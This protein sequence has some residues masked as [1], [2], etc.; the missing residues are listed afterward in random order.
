MHFVYFGTPRFSS[1][2]LQKIIA[3]KFIP[4]LVI[5]QPPRPRGRG[6]AVTPSPVGTLAKEYGIASIAPRGLDADTR[7]QLRRLHPDFFIVAAYGEIFKKEFLNIPKCGCLNVHASLLPQLRGASPVS[8]AILQGLAET[9]VT[10]ILMDEG[11]DTGPILAQ[12]KIALSPVETA[13][14]LTEKLAELGGELLISFL[15]SLDSAGLSRE[16]LLARAVLQD[17]SQATYTRKLKKEDGWIDWQRHSPQQIERMVR[18]YAP[19]PGV[20]TTL[21]NLLAHLGMSA[22]LGVDTK[23]TVKLLDVTLVDGAL[24]VNTLQLAGKNPISWKQF[25]NGFVAH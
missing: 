10:I 2:I 22:R 18:A 20:R 24:V 5:T 8:E 23:Q 21:G 1:I 9:G 4:S 25:V 6:R 11:V 16:S 14:T 3:A 12:K 15:K 19:W 13:I 17:D 7:E